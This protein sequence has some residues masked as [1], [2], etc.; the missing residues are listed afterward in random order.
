[1]LIVRPICVN[2][3]DDIC[4]LSRLAGPGFTSLAV[5]REVHK[6][7]IRH[8]INSF[9]DVKNTLPHHLYTLVLEDTSINEVIGI[10]SIKTNI[11]VKDPFFNFRILQL[12]Q[13]SSVTGSRFDMAVLVLVN[14]YAGS[15]EVASLFVKSEYRGKGAG[16]LISQAR[17]MLIAANEE[18]FGNKIISELRG[19]VSEN[20]DS[21]FWNAIGKKFFRMDFQSADEFSA[22]KDNQFIVELMPKHPIY[23]ALLPDNA[24]NVIGKTHPKGI[25]A[26]RYLESEGFRYDNTVDIFDAGPTMAVLKKDMRTLNESFLT[27]LSTDSP[28]LNYDILALV[29]NNSL[30]EFRCGLINLSK[31]DKNY[32][33]KFE[34]LEFL[35]INDLKTA[36]LWIKK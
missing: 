2:D 20:G 30:A 36:R 1:M 5:N 33:A 15:S 19:Q 10:S 24:Q 28:D 6:A 14:E 29:S 8:S 35:K 16:M 4:E 32:F 7:R 31:V 13:K 26:K 18:R 22:G 27:S 12:A 9:S 3:L 23:V 25:G 34:E 11:G 17:F 21:P